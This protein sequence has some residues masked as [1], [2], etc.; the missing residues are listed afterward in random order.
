MIF[1]KRLNNNVVVALD[2]NGNEQIL[3]GKG[4]GFQMVEGGSV[5]ESKIEK[6]FTLQD[7]TANHRLQE[8]F[9]TIPESYVEVAKEIVSYARIH[10]DNQISDNAIVSLCDHIYMSIKRK[11]ENMEVKNVMLWDIQKFYRDEYVIGLHAIAL[12][13]REFN[14]T[15]SED[16]AGFI[17]LHIVNSQLDMHKESFKQMTQVMQEIETII[18]ITFSIELDVTSVY[19][20][21]FITHLKFFAQRL[22]SDTFYQGGEVENMLALVREKYPSECACVEKI[23]EFLNKKYSYTLSEEEILYLSIHISRMIQVSK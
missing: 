19:Y 22:F 14:V 7:T 6:I 8:L 11:Q 4:L 18:R 15:L 5:E 21:R 23:S 1:K 13:E 17:A 2:D 9:A 16:E 10:I 3:C 12:I 20:Y